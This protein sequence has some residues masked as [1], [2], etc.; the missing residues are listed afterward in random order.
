MSKFSRRDFLIGSAH[1]PAFWL[2]DRWMNPRI[3]M[4]AVAQGFPSVSVAE[5]TDEDTPAQ[6]LQAALEG[7]GG[8]DR[9]VK[10]GQTVAIKP[11]ATW[12][13]PPHTASST[14]PEFLAAVIQAVQNAGANRII[15]MDHCSI[16][17][18][19]D[20]ALRISGISRAVKDMGAEGI[21]PDRYMAPLS[22]Y[23][24]IDLPYGRANASLGVIKAAV[25]ADIRINLAVAKSHNVT[26]LTMCL[27]HMMGFLQQ[28]GL[29][30][31]NLEQGIADLSTPSAIQ[32]QL[33]I[34]EA[35]RVRVPYGS[36]RV[37]AGPETEITHPHIIN[38][39]NT[40]IAGIDPV[41]IDS[42]GC[43][44]FFEMQP[45]ELTHLLLANE[46]G[47]GDMDVEAAIDDGRIQRFK[48]GVPL[49]FKATATESIED[50]IPN[51]SVPKPTATFLPG[52]E[53]VGSSSTSTLH[54]GIEPLPTERVINFAPWLNMVLV[55]VA[56]VVTGISLVILNRMREKL[57]NDNTKTGR[58]QPARKKSK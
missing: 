4:S 3:H 46:S 22:T 5:G 31:A 7:L 15:V 27:K 10:P 39:R 56:A 33:H 58:V 49:G 42:F 53:Q 29:L 2:L 18:G 6:I 9:F 16:E 45:Q 17:P 28:P 26:K 23:K 50:A 19:A 40:V 1:I 32:A 14:N 21:F 54:S 38:K 8:I 57:P 55:P 24:K 41:L 37:C 52:S 35:I 44:Q 20:E 12:A 25:D 30:H 47:C 13:Y 11:N 36:Y 43:V 48:V 51:P 34:L